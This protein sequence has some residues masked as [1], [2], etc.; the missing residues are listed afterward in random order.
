MKHTNALIYAINEIAKAEAED[1][2]SELPD[3]PGK[4]QTVSLINDYEKQINKL[5]QEQ[6]RFYLKAYK[7][8]ISKGI[9]DTF[10]NKLKQ[11]F[12][13]DKFKE[14]MRK[15]NEDYFL[16]STH[17]LT[18]EMLK[19]I[20]SKVNFKQI[21]KKTKQFIEN[22]SKEL[23]EIMQLSTHKKLQTVFENAIKNNL[24]VEEVA[25]QLE[26]LPEFDRSRAQK[27]AR[28]EMLTI[29]Q[30]AL[31]EAFEQ[32]PNV[33]GKQWKHNSITHPR[34]NHKTLDG[35]IVGIDEEF[36]LGAEKARFPRD[37]RLSP[38]ERINCR[39]TILPIYR[40]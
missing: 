30:I 14:K 23:A 38:K 34:H 36:D 6:K 7:Q 12:R 5:L 20:D 8:H 37:P 32:S 22:W 28:T 17:Y 16:K 13:I 27:V 26:N 35:V 2:M 29:S 25:K 21:N 31:N 10:L 15:A 33:I 40:N 39:C 19:E 1:L 9:F 18:G 24:S 3:F 11:L 4:P